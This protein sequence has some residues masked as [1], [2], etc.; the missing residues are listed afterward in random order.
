MSPLKCEKHSFFKGLSV[1][2][3]DTKSFFDKLF[4]IAGDVFRDHSTD[5]AEVKEIIIKGL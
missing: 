3:D 4:T 5:R 2:S 1:M